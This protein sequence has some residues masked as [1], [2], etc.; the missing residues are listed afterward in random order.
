MTES[1]VADYITGLVANPVVSRGERL[2]FNFRF[3]INILFLNIAC[4]LLLFFL[5]EASVI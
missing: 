5:G 1:I 3:F 4:S 2:F